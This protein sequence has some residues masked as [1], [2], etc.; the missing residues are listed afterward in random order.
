MNRMV[1]TEAT[2]GNIPI[3]MLVNTNIENYIQIHIYVGSIG[4]HT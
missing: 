1:N 2:Y 3:N 4:F